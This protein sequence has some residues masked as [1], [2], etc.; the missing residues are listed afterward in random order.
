MKRIMIILLVFS[1]SLPLCSLL[2]AQE[3]VEFG[4]V[5]T[6]SFLNVPREKM[7]EFRELWEKEVF[8]LEKQMPKKTT[9]RRSG[10]D[11]RKFNYTIHLPERRGGKDRRRDKN[12]RKL[13][14]KQGEDD[15]Q[16]FN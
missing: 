13:V 12:D 2:Y 14:R 11:R 9:D 6:M 8:S 3:E 4:S 16:K 10:S 7:D 15:N 1:F 5:F